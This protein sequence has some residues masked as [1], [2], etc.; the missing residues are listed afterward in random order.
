KLLS[1]VFLLSLF[2][3]I[4]Y[5]YIHIEQ[6]NSVYYKF[7]NLGLLLASVLGILSLTTFYHSQLYLKRH[8]FSNKQQAIYYTSLI[9]LITA[10]MSAYFAENIAVLWV[11]IEATTLFVSILIFHERSKDALE[12]AW[13]YLFVSSVGVAVAFIG[14]LF[15]SITASNNGIADLSLSHLLEISQKMNPIWLKMAFLL[16]LTGFSAKMGLFPLYTVAIDAHTVAPPP[17]S[18]FISTTLMNVGFLGIFRIFTII[19][20][21]EV[22]HWAQ[23]VLLI[24]GVLSVFMSAIQL[25]KVKHY[26]RMFAFSSLEHMGIVAIGLGVGG[27]GYYA[28]ILHIVFHSFVKAGLFYQIGQVHQ[29][30]KSYWIKDVSGYF[31]RNP[32]GGLAMILGV[33]SILAIPPSGLF[34]SEFL[35][36]KA[37]FVAKHYYIGIFVLIL[38]TVIIYSFSKNAFHLLY[39]DKKHTETEVVVANPYETI[40]QFILFGLVIYLGINPPIFFTDLIN[41]AIAILN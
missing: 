2:A 25:L 41:S 32:I 10:M 13:K 21:T 8:K 40:S 23:N 27:I 12:A 19:S 30:Y 3:I 16:V 18:A 17:I 9:M 31:K 4:T 39:D 29:F 36:F 15:L 5:A 14:I 37:M 28:A 20:Q 26:K 24:A 7:D 33:I 34:I 35:I 1:T 11:S 6:I 38:L 22:L